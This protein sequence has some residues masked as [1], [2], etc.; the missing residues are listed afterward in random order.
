MQGISFK[1][2]CYIGQELTARTHHTG[3]I[4]KRLMPVTL[5]A[6]VENVDQG[7][8]LETEGGKPAG[9][10][11]AGFGLLGLSLVRMAHAKEPLKLKSSGDTTVT[12]QA[13]VPDWWP[14]NTKEK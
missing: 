4:R 10:H 3:V 12:L 1:K 8:A 2:G 7:V 5:S 13:T 9:K 14:K 11:R 6:P